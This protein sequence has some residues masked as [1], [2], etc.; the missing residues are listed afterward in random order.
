MSVTAN[1]ADATSGVASYAFQYSTTNT[2]DG[3]TSMDT[4]DST[5]NS[6]TF[7]YQD[8]ALKYNILLKGNRKRQ[9]RKN[10]TKYCSKHYY[11]ESRNV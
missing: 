9:S 8:L 10:N 3:F 2:T 1:G 4:V 5:S 11:K 7:T 6:C